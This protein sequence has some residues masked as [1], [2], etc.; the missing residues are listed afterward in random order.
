VLVGVALAMG[1]ALIVGSAEGRPATL[2]LPS[3]F[4][5]IERGPAGGTMWQG[6]IRDTRE[7]T[8]RRPT[9]VYLPPGFS[10]ARRYPVL[11]LLCGFPGSPYEFSDGLQLATAADTVI[12]NDGVRAFVAVAPPAGLTA[13][14][15]GE[16]TGEWEDYVVQDVVPWID[17]H[18][19][20]IASAGGRAIAGLSA[21]GYGA[22]DIGLR[23]ATLFGTLESWSG[24]FRPFRDGSLRHASR[25]EL[26][27]HDPSKL[28][29]D[30]APVLHRVGTRFFISS[31]TT[32]D[33]VT[34]RWARD[35]TA[36]LSSLELP[37]ELW[38][39][40]GAHDGKFWRL[41]L[42]PALRYAFTS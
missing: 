32:H 16:W 4:E 31:A 39:R 6:V 12:A 18:L 42:G 17:A 10:R 3:S 36:E 19:P 11:Y 37:F 22:I 40:P 2:P 9:L 21:G 34:A 26:A 1:S 13:R 5:Q 35:F 33:R 7:P 23:H 38:L 24:Y 8:L 28:V 27:A 41:Q 29:R 30:E 15:N 14:Y 20:T 25:A